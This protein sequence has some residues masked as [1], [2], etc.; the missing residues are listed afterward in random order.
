L[1]GAA[2]ARI[3]VA[4]FNP[5]PQM[6]ELLNGL[7]KIRLVISEDFVINNPYKLEKLKSATLLSVPQDAEQGKL[8]AKVY[9]FKRK[10][11]TSCAILGSANLTGDGMFYNQEA[12]V[13]LDSSLSEN[14]KALR[15]IGNWFEAL[16]TTASK[17][18]LV[19]AKQIYDAASR[20]RIVPKSDET[21][22]N[23]AGYWALKTTAGG[24]NEKCYWQSFQAD[25]VI[26]IGWED[27]GV[28]PAAVTLKQLT[29]AMLKARPNEDLK[30][31]SKVK[32]FVELQPEAMVLLCNGY[33]SKQEKPVHIY[34]IARVI[35]PFYVD[36]ASTWD[37]TFKHEAAIQAMDIKMSRDALAAALG[38]GS[39]RQTIHSLE[40]K[41]FDRLVAE[42]KRRGLH[43]R[44]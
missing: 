16:A 10:N 40:K 43:V 18:D 14:R 38:K 21:S 25:R 30:A 8:H 4:F 36:K 9:L 1:G 39:M 22:A 15:D 34:G 28:D 19:Q 37:W 24:T 35:G 23:D 20:V 44:V 13:I 29:R 26:A 32:K 12:C 5:N 11:G 42:L 3:A 33:I 2:E 17:P 41:G 31:A 7:P 27:V 6:L